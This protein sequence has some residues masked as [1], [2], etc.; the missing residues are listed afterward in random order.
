MDFLYSS[1]LLIALV[2]GSAGVLTGLLAL[3]D[4]G[5]RG[6]LIRA[7]LSASTL[8]VFSLVISVGVHWQW[9]HGASSAEPMHTSQFVES[10]P[11]FLVTGGIIA[12]AL[13]ALLF[14]RH[15]QRAG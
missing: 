15:R 8:A 10:H 5:S 4:I 6:F 7:G 2:A 3:F 14:V 9:G 1:S 11:A 13:V 12:L